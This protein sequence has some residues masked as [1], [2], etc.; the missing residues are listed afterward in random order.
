MAIDNNPFADLPDAQSDPFADL[1]DAKKSGL[2]AALGSGI[3][4]LQETGYRAVKGFT[5]VGENPNDYAPG[6]V[7]RGIA[8]AIGQGGAL[9]RWADEGIQRNQEEAAQYQPAVSSYKDIGS[10]S[11]AASYVGEMTAQSI[12]MMAAAFNPVTAFAM[13]GGLANEA[14]EEQEDKQP[15][16]AVASGFG[17]MGLER[18]GAETAIGRV[19]G[20]EG[21]NIGKR[22]GQSM[23]GEGATET[24][25]EALAQW[26]GG[27]S[28][29]ERN[30]SFI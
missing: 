3:D 24:G 6:S 9:S 15:W 2:L 26:G 8:S 27:K 4:Q 28:I 30:A 10:V 25:Q 11:D 13:G 21:G 20:G 19:F 18:L 29:D 16:R 5:E 23:L 12:P 17:Q 22:I 14:Y 1:P 7:G